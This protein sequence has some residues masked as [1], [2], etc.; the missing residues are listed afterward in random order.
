ME[1]ALAEKS[2]SETDAVKSANQFIAVIDFNGMA[3][4]ALVELAIE[5]ADTDVD[6]GSGAASRRFR[7]AVDDRIEI[8][9]DRHAEPVGAH[10]ARQ[11]VGHVKTIERE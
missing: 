7:T 6:P 10:R 2:S 8:A 3:I 11:S 5:I 1:H 9:I 4:A